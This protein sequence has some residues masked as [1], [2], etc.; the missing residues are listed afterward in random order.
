[1]DKYGKIVSFDEFNKIPRNYLRKIVCTSGGF[2]PIHPGHAS[3]LI[4]SKQYGDTLVVVVN[5][6]WFLTDKKGKPFMDLKT[7]CLLVSCIREVDYIIPF[8]IENDTT[9]CVA[10]EKI[11][12]H[13]FTKGGD[14]TD[15][16][17]IPEWDICEKHN[18][19]LIPQ[20]G[21]KKFWSSS[22]LLLEWGEFWKAN[23]P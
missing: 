2:D 3:C 15:F 9:V 5:G 13:I 17:N 23:H 19:Q 1:M 6:D 18:I 12:P 4:E 21:L 14:R 10:L 7:R 22:D 8:E 16:T 20:V 11:K